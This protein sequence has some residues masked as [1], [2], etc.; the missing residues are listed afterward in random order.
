MNPPGRPKGESFE[1]Q[2]EGSPVSAPSRRNPASFAPERVGD[3]TGA[4]GRFG[5]QSLA[6]QRK[7]RS[8]RGRRR[9]HAAA[10]PR[11]SN[12]APHAVDAGR[13]TFR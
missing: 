11:P 2:R 4:P 6:R 13:R 5:R 12:R 10:A 7:G 3:D 1:R 8:L 9:L